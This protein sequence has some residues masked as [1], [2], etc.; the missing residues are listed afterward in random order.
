[1]TTQ[2]EIIRARAHDIEK[3]LIRRLEI[4][5]DRVPTNDEVAR[6]VKCA[7]HPSG[8]MEYRYLGKIFLFVPVVIWRYVKE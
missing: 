2:E 5:Y 3:E 4:I 1:M 6:D 8:A 7:V